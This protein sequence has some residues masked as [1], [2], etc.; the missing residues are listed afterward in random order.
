MADLAGDGLLVA[1]TAQARWVLAATVLGSGIA[2]LDATVVG[3]ALPTIGRDLRTGVA[4]LQWLVTAYTLTLAAFLLLGGALGDRLGRRRIFSIGVV[5]FAVA[6]AACAAAPTA[7][8]LIAARA[9]QGVGAALLTPGSLAILQASFRSE[10]RARAIGAW[11]G[12][13]G[14]ANAAGPLVGGELIAVSSWRWVFLI[15]VPIAAVTLALTSRHVPESRDESATGRLDVGGAVLAVCALTGLIYGLIEGPTRGWTDPV[16]VIMLGAAVAAGGAFVVLERRVGSPMLPLGIFASRQFNAANA[17]TFVVYAALSG[18]LFLLPTELQVA[19][20][21]SPAASGL[22]LLPV[23]AIMLFGSAPSGRLSARIGPRLQMGAGPLIVAAGL[24]LLSRAATDA[25]YATGVLPGVVVFGVGLACT[26]APLT[27]TA[28]GAAPPGHS[29]I[30]SAVNN[31]VARAGGLIAVAVLPPLAGI[32]G[33]TYLHARALSAGFRTAVLVAAGVCAAGGVLAA[34]T[35]RNPG[36]PT[37][38]PC[39][40]HCATDGPPLRAGT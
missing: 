25:S 28:M 17:T 35:I 32:T 21:Y 12:L 23:T 6:S 9:V 38:E 27:A 20:G 33:S 8:S 15:N 3:V 18:A 10:D 5:W 40:P 39:P 24:A 14:L 26:V 19:G 31:D 7:G 1:G 16:V 36:R 29:G 30:A 11:S 2:S 34:L 13:G 22:A 4:S 37:N